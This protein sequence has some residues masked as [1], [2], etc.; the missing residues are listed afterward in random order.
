MRGSERSVAVWLAMWAL[1]EAAAAAVPALVHTDVFVGGQD[2]YH[3]F[4]IPAI[5]VM[6]DGSVLALA[7]ARRHHGGDPGTP[8]QDID[9]VFKRSTDRGATWTGLQVLDD[10]GEMWSSANASTLVDRSN[11]RAWVVYLR[12]R[13]GRSTETARP[14][15]DDFQTHA[16][17]SDDRGQTWS[18][19]VDLTAAARD[20]ADPLWRASVPGPG[21]AIQIRGGRLVVPMWKSPFANFVLISDD[22]G[23]SWRRS[24]L[25]PNPRGGDENQLVE[26]ADGR[27][28]M[29]ARQN[30]GPHRW[31]SESADGGLTW[32]APR[33][34]VEVTPVM[35]AIERLGPTGADSGRILWTGPR[36]PG[37]TNLVARVSLD[38]GKTFVEER[39][40]AEGFAAYSDLV[41][42]RAG[43]A[44]VLWERGAERGYQ[45]ISFTF[46][47]REWLGRSEGR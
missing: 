26:L 27:I 15:T 44:G 35:C 12:S 10:A 25:V 22:H 16:R 43:S 1:A 23:R 28:L 32:S 45:F 2:G 11:G 21:G 5:E 20:L 8:K 14:G 6:A 34:G 18:E 4:R 46:L 41:A 38:E 3:M 29:D 17:W 19:P 33:P 39:L 37:R 13:P 9:L 7:E 31:L 36:G 47:S 24:G 42:L 40:I 30:A